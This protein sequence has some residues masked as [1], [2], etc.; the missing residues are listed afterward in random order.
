MSDA[1]ALGARRIGRHSITPLLDGHGHEPAREVLTN[2]KRGADP[3]LG[4]EDLLDE[5]GNLPLEVG[6]HLIRTG[7]G[8]VVLVDTGV[9]TVDNGK[10]R[11][12]Q[13]LESLRAQGFEPEDVTDVLLTHLHFDHVGWSTKKGEVVF[14]EA[15][16][17]VHQRDWD[18]FVLADDAEPGAVRK[19]SPLEARLS[20]YTGEQ[21]LMPGIDARPV[22]GHTPGSTAFVVS[23]GDER[24]VLIG[25]MAHAYIELTEPGWEY[26]HDSDPRESREARA[27]LVDEF[28]DT[29]VPIIGAHFPDMRAGLLQKR[30]GG[31]SWT[32]T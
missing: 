26:V 18:H 16:Y 7:E 8:R 4:H 12:G 13:F 1:L 6:G 17:H 29:G 15:T 14:S 22:P 10:Y 27:A 20:T 32:W 23:D 3:W 11:G 30:D 19:L 5:K 2:P 31:I 25:D 9:G 28:A 24:G 21:T